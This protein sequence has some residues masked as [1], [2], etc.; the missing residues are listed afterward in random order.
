MSS[1]KRSRLAYNDDFHDIVRASLGD[2]VFNWRI[3]CSARHDGD[4]DVTS[5]E[6]LRML[7]ARD[8]YGKE[9]MFIHMIL[10][11]MRSVVCELGDAEI[12]AIPSAKDRSIIEIVREIL[13]QA[14]ARQ[15][16]PSVV[17]WLICHSTWSRTTW[18]NAL[19]AKRTRTARVSELLD[20]LGC[21]TTPAF[22]ALCE[23]VN[24]KTLVE[25]P[26]ALLCEHMLIN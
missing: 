3:I 12:A 1:R 7:V 2:D 5:I 14:T 16:L 24:G 9:A 26:R 19:K 20:A 15:R 17:T 11:A 13:H 10:L 6:Y 25:M 22:D 4:P 8:R 23:K 18:M 21:H